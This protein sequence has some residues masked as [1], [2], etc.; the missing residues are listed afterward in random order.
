MTA[1]VAVIGAGPAGL[2]V[3]R[4]L[5]SQGLQPSIFEEGSSLGGQWT[6][7]L[8]RSGVWPGMHTNTS[9]I[10]TAFSI[11]RSTAISYF[12]RAQTFSTTCTVTPA[13]SSWTPGF[14]SGVRV[15]AVARAGQ[16]WVVSHDGIDE[17]FDRVVIATGRFHSAFV[18]P[19][20]GLDTFAGSAGA[21][22][23]YEYRGPSPLIATSA[24]WSRGGAR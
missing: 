19:V 6:A 7:R 3:S 2:V 21:I 9:R 14:G 11:C 5:L 23:S 10:L 22:T 13:C 8:G 12:P 24:C 1:N 17:H 4:W 20:P 18:P 16:R 15:D